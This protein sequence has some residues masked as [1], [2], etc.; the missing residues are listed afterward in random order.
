MS[1]CRLSVLTALAA[2]LLALVAC[3]SDD[4][5]GPPSPSTSTAD[6]VGIWLLDESLGGDEVFVYEADGSFSSQGDDYWEVGT[7]SVAGDQTT[8]AITHASDPNEVGTGGS[9]TF[10]IVGDTLTLTSHHGPATFQR[11]GI[12]GATAVDTGTVGIWDD[13]S[14]TGI[15][16][17]SA[18]G[19][20]FEFDPADASDL[21]IGIWSSDGSTASL[22]VKGPG[23]SPLLDQ[24]LGPVTCTSTPTELT[25]E[26]STYTRVD[27]TDNVVPKIAQ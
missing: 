8:Y 12:P 7:V 14:S 27:T 19:V 24:T 2:A 1:S 4:D 18:S 23:T 6:L 20:Y 3:G 9:A 10:G 13:D 17:I 5:A 26:T 25:I 15:V 16:R 22:T 11:I 21:V